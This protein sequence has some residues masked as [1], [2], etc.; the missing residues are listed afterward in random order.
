MYEG[1][2]LSLLPVASDYGMRAMDEDYD[3]R[4]KVPKSAFV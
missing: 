3:G 1:V 4:F 2:P